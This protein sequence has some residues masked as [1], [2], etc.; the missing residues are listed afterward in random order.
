MSVA[1]TVL[2]TLII[3]H[4]FSSLI[5]RH[6]L[7]SIKREALH[8]IARALLV[9]GLTDTVDDLTPPRINCDMFAQFFDMLENVVAFSGDGRQAVIEVHICF[10]KYTTQQKVF[11]YFM[12]IMFSRL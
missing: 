8:V 10:F 3:T 11:D 12:N 1:V 6:Y 5:G 9:D 4:S 2:L 7:S